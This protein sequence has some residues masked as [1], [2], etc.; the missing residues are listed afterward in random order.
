MGAQLLHHPKVVGDE[1]HGHTVFPVQFLQKLQNLCLNGHIQRRGRLIQ[2]QQPGP[3]D[4]GGRD[5]GALQHTAGQFVR[6]LVV[7][8]LRV[9]QFHIGQRL[10]GLFPALG[11]SQLLCVKQQRFLHLGAHLHQRV[12]GAHRLLKHH[13]DL[14]ALPGAEKGPGQVQQIRAVQQDLAGIA[15]LPPW[16]KARHAHGRDGLARTGLAHQA[17]NLAIRDG[18]GDARHGFPCAVVEF[19]MKVLD[20]QH[21]PTPL[22]WRFM[23]SPM[24]PTPKISSTMVMPVHSAYQGAALSILWDSD[25]M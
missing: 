5:H 8:A 25:S 18:E 21:Q 20:L 23:P 11:R 15:A 1:Q 4:N 12:H 16:Q 14:L 9:G 19:Y 7:H 2:Q 6:V 13:A 22:F 3:G 10:N 17:Q 24:R